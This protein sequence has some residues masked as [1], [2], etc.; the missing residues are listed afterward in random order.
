MNTSVMKRFLFNFL[1]LSS[2]ITIVRGSWFQTAIAPSS[3]DF[4][5]AAF[6]SP[7]TCVMVGYNNLEGIIIR[8][9]NSGT[10]WTAVDNT[11]NQF[12]D[13]AQIPINS[14]TYFLAVAITGEIY[15]SS[16]TGL[17]FQSVNNS[18][19]SNEVL[20]GVAIGSN[21]NSYAV[22]YAGSPLLSKIYNSS[23]AIGNVYTVWN[24]ITPPSS[25]G[26]PQV[27][28]SALDSFIAD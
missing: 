28:S 8:T 14:K 1:L 19:S 25:P 2:T 26:S 21:Y 4:V 15:L 6:S 24:D 17:T 9:I 13:V 3:Y 27:I 16:D 11:V 23:F 7:T 22:G 10:T 20:N 18:V 5:S 12:S